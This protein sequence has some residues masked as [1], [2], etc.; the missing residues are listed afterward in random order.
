MAFTD[1]PFTEM[2]D[3]PAELDEFGILRRGGN[4]AALAPIE[5]RIIEV[6]L[7]RSGRVVRRSEFAAVWPR[8]MPAPRAVDARLVLLR[9]RIAPLGLHIQ[10]V[11]ARGFLL[12][13][14]PIR[15]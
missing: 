9:E 14:T 2:D 3:A 4:W 6:F 13:I 10:T 11:R 7:A 15:V 1:T 12:D 8:G 5:A